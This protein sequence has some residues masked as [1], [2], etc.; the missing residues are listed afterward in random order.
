MP[1]YYKP[2]LVE[3]KSAADESAFSLS[4]LVRA[5]LLQRP[6]EKALEN[7]VSARLAGAA[8][9]LPRYGQL[10]PF[11]ALRVL[12]TADGP[13]TATR[14][15]VSGSGPA[16]GYLVGTEKK[17][18][19]DALR[20]F[21]IAAALGVSTIS[22]LKRDLCVPRFTQGATAQWVGEAEAPAE[23]TPTTGLVSLAPKRLAAFVDYSRELLL[24]SE[25]LE[26]A[27]RRDLAAAIASALDRALLVGSG[28]GNEPCGIWNTQGIGSVSG[29]SFSLSTAASIIRA[30][31]D[32]NVPLSGPGCGWVM[33]PAVAELLRQREAASGSGFLIDGNGKMLSF[34]VYVTSAMPA[35]SILFGNFAGGVQLAQWG[36][37]IDILINP[38]T[39]SKYRTVSIIAN[40]WLD[41]CCRW[42]LAFCKVTGVS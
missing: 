29:T 13:P 2:K 28:S 21:S 42:P 24:Q 23:S 37:G 14:D 5:Q 33:P 20:P 17:G 40:A 22:G 34:P 25:D 38:Y 6:E 41:V 4:R 11:A 39:G 15:L 3:S 32:G 8:G 12:G 26:A 10:V 19:I 16:G 7:T 35:A 9:G 36:S 30:V 31:E 27:L 18:L 1:I